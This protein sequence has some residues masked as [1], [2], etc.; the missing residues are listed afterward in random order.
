MSLEPEK[1]FDKIQYT[2]M[3]NHPVEIRDIGD[4]PQCNN[5]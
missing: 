2:F 1:A 3:I 5:S 4:I